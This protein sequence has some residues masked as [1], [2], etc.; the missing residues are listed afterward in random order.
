MNNQVFMIYF[1]LLSSVSSEEVTS[2]SC[3]NILCILTR[4][5]SLCQ[6]DTWRTWWFF[7]YA[8]IAGFR[9]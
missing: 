5:L 4:T 7:T 1:S 2:V 8:L 6:T 3:T 9:P